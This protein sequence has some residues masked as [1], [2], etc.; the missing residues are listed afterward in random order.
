MLNKANVAISQFQTKI[1]KL[2]TYEEFMILLQKSK[3][4]FT[5]G[6]GSFSFWELDWNLL[7]ETISG[8]L[9]VRVRAKIQ[10]HKKTYEANSW[11]SFRLEEPTEVSISKLKDRLLASIKDSIEYMNFEICT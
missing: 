11:I 8:V 1:S 3:I 10:V 4:D 2:A 5:L 9:Q 6:V 7:K